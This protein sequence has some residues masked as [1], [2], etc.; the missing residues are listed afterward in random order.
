[1]APRYRTWRLPRATLRLTLTSLW[2]RHRSICSPPCLPESRIKAR[3]QL[4][5]LQLTR[6]LLNATS[7]LQTGPKQSFC[8]EI[9]SAE[10]RLKGSAK[11][12]LSLT[13]SM[14]V[15]RRIAWV[16][17]LTGRK[18]S[19]LFRWPEKFVLRRPPMSDTFWKREDAKAENNFNRREVPKTGVLLTLNRSRVEEYFR[20]RT[21]VEQL[22]PAVILGNSRVTCNGLAPFNK[23]GT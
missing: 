9:H 22:P 15:P 1:M 14:A 13:K 5:S 16:T 3:P 11:A 2:L 17:A 21:F 8:L 12:F 18:D 20:T 4:R 23:R 19:P 7:E 10:P 6:T